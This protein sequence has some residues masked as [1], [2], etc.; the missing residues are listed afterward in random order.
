MRFFF[1]GTLLDPELRAAVLGRRL[2][3]AASVPALLAG[4]RRVPVVGA[5][6]PT[7]LPDPPA[8]A[9]GRLVLGLDAGAAARITWYESDDYDLAS[10]WVAT[11]AGAR[12]RA[13][14]FVA[15][16]GQPAGRG[17]WTYEAWRRRHRRDALAHAGA[18]LAACRGARLDGLVAAWRQRRRGG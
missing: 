12:L 4:Y 11:P 7:L 18:A 8:R 5:S 15:G 3:A 9:V 2:G 14:L 17:A 6:Y 16:P 10:G 1:Y 13:W